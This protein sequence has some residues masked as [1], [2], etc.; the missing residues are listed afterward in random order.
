[1]HFEMIRATPLK[2]FDENAGPSLAK[3]GKLGGLAQ[4]DGTVMK[5]GLQQQSAVTST[6]KALSNLSTSQ[7]NIRQQT[8]APSV[9]PVKGK[10]GTNLKTAVKPKILDEFYVDDFKPVSSCIVPADV[11]GLILMFYTVDVQEEMLCTRLPADDD[12]FDLKKPNIGFDLDSSRFSGTALLHP[13]TKKLNVVVY[14]V[15]CCWLVLQNLAGRP[16]CIPRSEILRSVRKTTRMS[17]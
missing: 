14:D 17:T 2:I 12:F 16:I 1:V 8:P 13:D 11:I 10:I 6:R 15:C 4:Q 7:I 5:R 3:Q 9:G